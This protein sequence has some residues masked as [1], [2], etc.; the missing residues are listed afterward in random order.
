MPKLAGMP[1][2]F[3]VVGVRSCVP[4]RSQNAP[5]DKAGRKDVGVAN[6]HTMHSECLGPLL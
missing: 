6:G 2:V 3:A 4:A 5:V 1:K